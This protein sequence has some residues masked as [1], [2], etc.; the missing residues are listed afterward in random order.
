MLELQLVI[1]F[2]NLSL[3]L[4]GLTWLQR[5]TNILQSV[6]RHHFQTENQGK[7]LPSQTYKYVSDMANT[8]ID[9]IIFTTFE[10]GEGSVPVI[11]GLVC[12]HFQ[13]HFEIKRQISE[14]NR[15]MHIFAYL[16]I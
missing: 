14:M 16:K 6:S 2:F 7:K 4:P 5:L 1:I 3:K 10:A 8:A 9:T 13:L 12:S 15:H 11:A